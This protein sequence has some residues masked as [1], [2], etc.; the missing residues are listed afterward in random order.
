MFLLSAIMCVRASSAT[1]RG[2]Y[3]GTRYTLKPSSFAYSIS[4][5]S[6]PAHRRVIEDTPQF[7]RMSRTGADKSSFTNA[8]IASHLLARAAVVSFRLDSIY[9]GV[10]IDSIGLMKSFT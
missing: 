2:E 8:L 3:A 4:S 10:Q 5:L 9:T 7:F 1:E 6:N